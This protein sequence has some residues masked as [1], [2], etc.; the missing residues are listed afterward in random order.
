MFFCFFYVLFCVFVLGFWF[1]V[2]FLWFKVGS[3]MFSTGFCLV[4]IMFDD[5][6]WLLLALFLRCYSVIGFSWGFQVWFGLAFEHV[7]P[8]ALVLGYNLLWSLQNLYA[9]TKQPKPNKPPSRNQQTQ[10]IS[11]FLCST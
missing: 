1:L 7:S 2:F 3:M 11:T 6:L 4:G 9:L 10:V 5:L 8:S